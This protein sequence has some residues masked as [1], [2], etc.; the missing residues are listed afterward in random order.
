VDGQPV[1]QA[2]PRRAARLAG[3]A[4]IP[5]D[6]LTNGVALDA[7]IADNLAVDRYNRPPFTRR[8]MLSPAALRTPGDRR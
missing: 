2:S 1:Q 6:R 8:G 5:E 7:S 3:V 4:H